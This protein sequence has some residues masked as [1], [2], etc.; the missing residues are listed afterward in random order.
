MVVTSYSKT[1]IGLLQVVINIV[2]RKSC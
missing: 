1:K 2:T